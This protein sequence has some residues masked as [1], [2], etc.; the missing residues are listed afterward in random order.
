MV[1]TKHRIASVLVMLFM[2]VALFAVL[3]LALP[4]RAAAYTADA[5]PAEGV[6]AYTVDIYPVESD[7][8]ILNDWLGVP[9]TD[10]NFVK[11]EIMASRGA[12]TFPTSLAGSGFTRI[13]ISGTNVDLNAPDNY[14]NG[15]IAL[16]FSWPLGQIAPTFTLDT[17]TNTITMDLSSL[18]PEQLTSLS[19]KT[20][21]FL[22]FGKVTDDDA[23]IDVQLA[24]PA[25]NALPPGT[26]YPLSDTHTVLRYIG[27]LG[28]SPSFSN[29]GSPYW[30]YNACMVMEAGTSIFRVLTD[31]ASGEVQHLLLDYA[32]DD[33]A[34]N[35]GP[36]Y[37]RA[38]ISASTG[39]VQFDQ[40]C[41]TVPAGAPYMLDENS[42]GLE[43][44]MYQRLLAVY[45]DR[46]VGKFGLYADT[47]GQQLNDAWWTAAANS[48]NSAVLNSLHAG[49]S[50]GGLGI[51][52]GI[53]AAQ[54]QDVSP[55]LLQSGTPSILHATGCAAC[56]A[57]RAHTWT[58][59]TVR[60]FDVDVLNATAVNGYVFRAVVGSLWA[61]GT[62][63]TLMHCMG[64]HAGNA[65][66]Q[67]GER[68]GTGRALVA[69]AHRYRVRRTHTDPRQHGFSPGPRAQPRK[70]ADR[71]RQ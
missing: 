69:V 18:T 51:G 43:A 66:R 54:R 12:V 47:P 49:I 61:N 35:T 24:R 42:T 32:Y 60:L 16:P 9:P 59:S 45:N 58:G 65:D 2:V 15:V 11:N 46:V 26:S 57:I 25:I 28:T 10:R 23:S 29:L 55:Q 50:V 64:G 14:V 13:V 7:K 31:P 34:G 63:L 17:G 8:D 52:S 70:P 20:L 53:L 30:N 62:P 6:D 5:P 21:R 56:D 48:A 37:Y 3:G 67:C 4:L 27:P 68:Q 41:D 22:V 19:G 39:A 1:K 36:M 71:G 38:G 33:G 44:D 40:A